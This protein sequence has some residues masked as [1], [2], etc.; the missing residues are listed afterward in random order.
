M[1]VG[2]LANLLNERGIDHALIGIPEAHAE[3]LGAMAMQCA[4]ALQL[5]SDSDVRESFALFL[6]ASGRGRSAPQL[7]NALIGKGPLPPLVDDAVQQVEAELVEAAGGTLGDLADLAVRSWERLRIRAALRPWRR[8]GQHFLRLVAPMADQPVT[9]DAIEA[10]LEIVERNR[11]EALIDRDYSENGR[12]RL[13]TYHQTKGREADTVIHVF[14][15]ND[16]FGKEREPYEEA[17]RLLNVAISRARQ[18]VVII[19]PAN[20]H[21]LIE[22]FT[23]LR[24]GP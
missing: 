19:L 18:R 2:Q 16:Y 10:L 21:G 24:N 15:P 23:A 14:L 5:V 9:A 7:A 4:F 17:S 6:T 22:P 12:I 1:A 8:A 20:P 13:M 11:T 3:G